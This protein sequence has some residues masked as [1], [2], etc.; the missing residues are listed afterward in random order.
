MAPIPAALAAA[1]VR[2][3]V[4]VSDGRMSGT[5]FGTVVLHVAP[6]AAIGGPLAL[7]ADGDLICLD[8]AARRL[9]LL[10]DPAELE[11]RRASWQPG[12]DEHL[13]WLAKALPGPRQPSAAW[14]RPRLPD[15]P[16]AGISPLRAARGRTLVNTTAAT[17]FEGNQ[18]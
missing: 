4:R 10:V 16:D 14:L 2:D 11:R 8:V 1:G 6:E 12:V 13:S 15:Q 9:D 3:M 7:V 18:P 17:L 5:S